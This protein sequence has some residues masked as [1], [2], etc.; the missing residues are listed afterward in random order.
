MRRWRLDLRCSVVN[1]RG[2]RAV[3]SAA[4][5]RANLRT[6]SKSNA[7]LKGNHDVVAAGSWRQRPRVEFELA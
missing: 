2:S 7:A 4:M 3:A 5:S 6:V 1:R